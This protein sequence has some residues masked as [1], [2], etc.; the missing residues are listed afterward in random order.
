[1]NAPANVT[2][3]LASHSA[4]A[5]SQAQATVAVALAWASVPVGFPVPSSVSIRIVTLSAGAPFF[6][7]HRSIVVIEV[8]LPIILWLLLVLPV[9]SHILASVA[10]I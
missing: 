9:T 3:V 6:L 4:A 7:S 10:F 2:V 8:Q 1:M 5:L